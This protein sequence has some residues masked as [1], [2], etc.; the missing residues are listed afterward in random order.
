MCNSEDVRNGFSLSSSQN[1]DAPDLKLC[2]KHCTKQ[3]EHC[4]HTLNETCKVIHPWYVKENVN[5]YALHSK[6]KDLEDG[7]S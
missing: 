7:R 2:V 5:S 6:V 4:E 1:R 3:I